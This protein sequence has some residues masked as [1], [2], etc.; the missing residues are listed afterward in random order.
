MSEITDIKIAKGKKS[1]RHIYLDN[2]YVCS[3]DEFT[4]FK[5]KLKV[6]QQISIQQLEDITF[7]SEASTAFEKAV[8]L[9]S[10][11]PKTR[12]QVYDYLKEKGYL[13]KLC[14]SAVNKLI[15]YRYI[16]DEQY[17]RSYVNC[18]SQKYGK[19]KM[20]FMLA[21]RGVSHQIIE[22]VLLELD[23]Q[24]DVAIEIAIKYMNKKEKTQ[25]N[26]DKLCRYLASKGF[27]W[28]DIS[29]ALNYIK[30]EQE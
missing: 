3:L 13:P 8:D 30:K 11:T 20:E 16:D 28:D 17:A 22:Q 5:Y 4:V 14:E 29:T 18:Y 10:K 25:Q 24:N 1:R 2:N 7:E 9:I 15:E 12:K 26:Y 23:S 19:K 27:G 21:Q 6:G